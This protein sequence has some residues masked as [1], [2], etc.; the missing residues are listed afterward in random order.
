MALRKIQATHYDLAI[1]DLML[2][3][4]DGVLLQTKIRQTDPE[5]S[6]RVIFTTGYTDQASVLEFLRRQ[7]KAFL[8]KPFAPSQLIDAVQ[9]SLAGAPDLEPEPG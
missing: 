4:A 5:L 9:R 2:P 3:D 7:G 8:G 6:E 1:L